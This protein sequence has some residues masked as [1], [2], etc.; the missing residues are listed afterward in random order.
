MTQ[1]DKNTLKKLCEACMVDLVY[2][3]SE[4][5]TIVTSNAKIIEN[6]H[7]NYNSHNAIK[8]LADLFMKIHIHGWDTLTE[9]EKFYSGIHVRHVTKISQ[10]HNFN[11]SEY[12]D[13]NNQMKDFSELINNLQRIFQLIFPDIRDILEAKEVIEEESYRFREG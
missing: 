2:L 4:T 5:F 9:N 13:Y 8:S 7:Y 6:E 3:A 10:N 1:R 12:R 11:I